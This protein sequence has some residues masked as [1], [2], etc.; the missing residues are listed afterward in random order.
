MST[1]KTL[2]LYFLICFFP[3]WL[4]SPNIILYDKVLYS[5]PYI[6]FL[7][8]F[9][10]YFK[11]TKE[12]KFQL[13]LLSIITTFTIDQN[14]SLY[15]NVI[16]PNFHY[17]NQSLPNIYYADLLLIIFLMIFFIILFFLL[18]M[19]IIRIIFSFLLVIF[20]FK[21]YD[22]ITNPIKIINFN[23]NFE[24]KNKNSLKNKALIIILDEMSGMDSTEKN[25]KYA[26]NF[27]QEINKLAVSHNLHLYTQ[28]YSISDNTSTSVPFTLNFETNLPTTEIRNNYIKKN[29]STYNEYDV[30]QNTLFDKFDNISVIQNVHLNF[31]L[32][33]NVKKCKQLNPY[34]NKKD[35]L[36][37]FKNNLFTHFFSQWN[38][39]GSSFARLFFKSS[40]MFNLTDSVLEP[41]SH[42]IYLP[43]IFN[44]LE[45]DIKKNKFN[46]I[47]AHILSPHVPYGFSLDCKYDGMK[48]SHNNHMNKYE[49]YEQHNVERACMVKILDNFFNKI[50][51]TVDYKNLDIFIFSDHGSRITSRESFSSIFLSKTDDTFKIINKKTLINNEIKRIFTNRYN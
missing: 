41:E 20:I 12:S 17:L 10:I 14:L 19:K 5:L 9:I 42:K 51:G 4:L 25:Y 38:L 28:S 21:I 47:F 46:L 40:R 7:L 45:I 31:C 29:T 18:R 23:N 13:V 33:N 44:Q 24:V 43:T 6:F 1:K 48:S 3:V 22:V 11:Q 34:I 35:Y 36:A 30:I 50:K 2:N 16:K 8:A 37:G 26:D 49:K 15:T 32:H 27:L 39:D